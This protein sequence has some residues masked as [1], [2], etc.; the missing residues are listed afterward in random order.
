MASAFPNLERPDNPA[1][2]PLSF[3]FVNSANQITVSPDDRFI[4]VD[5]NDQIELIDTAT[6]ALATTQPAALT[7]NTDGFNFQAN[8]QSLFIY[9]SDGFI[10]RI[11]VDDPLNDVINADVF[12]TVATGSGPL[13]TDPELDAQHLF[14]LNTTTNILFA[15]DITSRTIT[16]QV[17]TAPITGV[18]DMAYVALPANVSGNTGGDTDKLIITTAT[19]QI[20]IY[21]ENL[22]QVVSP[23]TLSTTSLDPVCVVGGNHTLPAIAVSPN[24]EL[25]FVLDA[26]A[27]TIHVIDTILNSEVDTD[28]NGGN[29]ITPICLHQIPDNT[30]N[31]NIRDVVAVKV[32]DPLNATLAY[33]TGDDGVTIFSFSGVSPFTFDFED[34]DAATGGDQSLPLSKTPDKINASSQADGYIYTA[35]NDGSISVISE[36][37]FI[38]ISAITPTTVTGAAPA[39]TV[40]FQSDEVCSGCAY[41]VVLNGDIK[42]S[43]TLL[44]GTTFSAADVVN[45]DLTTPAIDINTFAA[46]TFVEGTNTIF[47]FADDAAG[48]TGRDSISLTVDFPPPDVVIVSTGFGNAKGF[49]TIVRLTQE[50]IKQYNIYV[51]E[52]L[53]QA[54]PTCPGGLDFGSLTT[55]TATVAQPTEGDNIKITITGLTNGIAYCVGVEAEDNAG[56]RSANKTVA[57]DP[58]IPEVTV[59]ILGTVGE[60]GCSLH[61]QGKFSG[62]LVVIFLGNILA[63]ILIRKNK[64][65]L[66]TATPECCNLLQLHDS[67]SRVAGPRAAMNR[68]TPGRKKFFKST[69]FI[70]L[71]FFFFS[72]TAHALEVTDQHWSAQIQGGF[73]LPT[74]NNVDSFLGKCCNGMYQFTFGRIWDSKYEVNVGVAFMIEDAM[75]RGIGTGRISDETFNF[76]VLPISNSFVYRAD[77]KENQLFVPYVGAGFDYMYFRENLQEQITQGWK[78]G[79]HAMAGVQILMEFIDKFA[80]GLEAEGINDI[81][82]TLEG[83]WNQIDN[84]GAGPLHFNGFTASAGLLFEF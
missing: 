51:L 80:D 35:N 13:V 76:F 6:W 27:N 72:G 43:G 39:F 75:A 65:C 41:R 33:V 31:T 68:C 84:F 73:F 8:S 44:L 22:N 3:G 29:G 7:A 20:L 59:G 55:P 56:N 38:T 30:I 62:S 15:Y 79:Y 2:K 48:N 32:N 63:L 11:L 61:P 16:G 49:V 69:I 42:E 40:T 57:V 14:I 52:A 47:I 60:G 25:A 46:G 18:L 77:Y 54:N 82:F 70:F 17:A 9:Q 64:V 1:L 83:R 71:I 50:D 78:F 81:Y 67:R 53:D 4:V 34:F 28:N 45:V 66:S 36:N 37:P 74:D 24:R 12:A 21:D 23:I 26:T 5:D 10:T 58:I 19:T